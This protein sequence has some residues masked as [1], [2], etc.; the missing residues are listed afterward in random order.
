MDQT[1]LKGSETVSY[2]I[3]SQEAKII[4]ITPSRITKLLFSIV[5][6]L[7]VA[8]LIGVWLVN[9]F[10][11]GPLRWLAKMFHKRFN[12]VN[13]MNFPSF[14]SATILFF[15]AVLL[16]LIYKLKSRENEKRYK[17]HWLILSLFFLFLCFDEFASIHEELMPPM[18]TRFSGYFS[19][20]LPY[21]WVVPYSILAL[22]IVILFLKF[23]FSL[24]VK[25]RNLI[26][27]SGAIYVLAAVGCEIIEGYYFKVDGEN[28]FYI[29]LFII[30]EEIMEMVGIAIFIYAL[31]DYIVASYPK[32][33]ICL[34]KT[35]NA[36]GSS[37]VFDKYNDTSQ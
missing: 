9:M 28:S 11:N 3:A 24:P 1:S 33:T 14:F 2:P 20:W 7:L 30:I 25:T 26:L 34:N 13:E 31:L 17:N 36:E 22:V 21:G 29:K 8:H 32:L 37:L 12:L 15:A 10:E 27:L 4:L 35:R 19:E 5:G 6:F 23:V 16:F 18:S